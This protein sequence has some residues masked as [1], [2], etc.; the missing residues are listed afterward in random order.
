MDF[1]GL[2]LWKMAV[3]KKYFRRLLEDSTAGAGGDRRL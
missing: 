2:I 3:E 1:V